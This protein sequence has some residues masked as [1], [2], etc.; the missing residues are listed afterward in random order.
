MDMSQSG[1]NVAQPYNL[2]GLTPWLTRGDLLTRELR[3][4]ELNQP[5]IAATKNIQR[6]DA[7]V[8]T[9]ASAF[10]GAHVA[11]KEAPANPA[12]VD[13][14]YQ[15]GLGWWESAT[16]APVNVFKLGIQ[17]VLSAY[18]VQAHTAF[19]TFAADVWEVAVNAH[20]Q[21]LAELRGARGK[22]K[23][24]DDFGGARPDDKSIR[25][26]V[27]EREGYDLRDK[28]EPCCATAAKHASILSVAFA[29]RIA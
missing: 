19:E 26:D 28:W 17:G 25:L 14:F 8:Q 7:I 10:Y 2:P 16:E 9:I 13:E 24:E 11:T 5:Y 23:S 29:K 12:S 3:T 4:A 6:A 18:L 22:R 1:G 21:I 27:L 20:P 15:R